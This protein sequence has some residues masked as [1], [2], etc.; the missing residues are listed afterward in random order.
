MKQSSSWEADSYISRLLQNPKYHY[1]V[2]KSQPLESVPTQGI[3]YTSS[4]PALYE[5][6][7]TAVTDTYS[8][9]A[10]LIHTGTTAN[11]YQPIFLVIHTCMYAHMHIFIHTC[12]HALMHTF[13]HIY[14]YTYIHPYIHTFIHSYIVRTYI[15]TSLSHS[16]DP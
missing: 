13:I 8:K 6:I 15:H 11:L 9:K 7:S 2:R 12:T 3:Q 16:M 4:H 5:P 14:K 1:S 10:K